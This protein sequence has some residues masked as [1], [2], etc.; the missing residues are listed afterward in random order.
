MATAQYERVGKRFG[1][2]VGLD[3]FSLRV[4]DGEMVAILGPSGCGK[5]TLLRLTAGLERP[6]S[7]EIRIGDRRI[8]T[9]PPHRRD[10]AMVFQSYALYPHLSVR[11]NIEFPLRRQ[12]LPAA[13]RAARVDQIVA[14]LDLGAL[15][16]RRPAAL[17]GGQRQ[18]VAL[19][20]ALVRQ[21]KLFLLDEPLSNLDARLRLGVRQYLR[22]L[23][24]RLHVTAL[25]VTHDQTEAMTLG[26]RVVVLHA[27]R[28]QQVDTPDA[29]YEYPANAFVAG[30]VGTPPMNLLPARLDGTALSVGSL[31]TTLPAELHTVLAAHQ[32]AL[33]VGVRPEAFNATSPAGLAAAP[34]PTTVEILGSE[35]LARASIG[36]LPVI[37]RLPGVVRDLPRQLYAGFEALHFFAASAD[38]AR[39]I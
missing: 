33:Q 5:S 10:V 15:L 36:G 23:Q 8:D 14:A 4:A 38:G 24:R 35:T 12:G 22:A 18:R 30:F 25:Y 7:G 19:A 31:Q 27:G 32:G 9:L 26:D 16:D 13:E 29:V 3:D 11:G 1:A 28:I 17:S 21:P 37:V 6:S 34:D 39:L 20:R 2:V